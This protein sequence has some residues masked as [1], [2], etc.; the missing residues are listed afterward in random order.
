MDAASKAT[1][2]GD[3]GD[4]DFLFENDSAYLK[5]NVIPGTV[6]AAGVAK[7]E[8]FGGSTGATLVN[9]NQ[10]VYFGQGGQTVNSDGRTSQL[11]PRPQTGHIT[12]LNCSNT[13]L[14]GTGQSQTITTRVNVGNTL[15][16]CSI[17][18]DGR[19]CSSTAVVPVTVAGYRLDWKLQTSSGAAPSG[20]QC[21]VKFQSP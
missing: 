2:S 15:A 17:A 6:T 1:F 19:N 21:E 14:V 7:T 11:L 20:V 12:G 4:T 10:T 16:T 9:P 13:I 18:D 3:Y 5:T 8:T